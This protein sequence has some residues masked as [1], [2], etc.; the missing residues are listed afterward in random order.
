MER[1][2][3]EKVLMAFIM[4]VRPEESQRTMARKLEILVRDASLGAGS[5]LALP[6]A[7][8]Y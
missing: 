5:S 6:N 1:F 7:M 8:N 3:P 4:F 2:Q